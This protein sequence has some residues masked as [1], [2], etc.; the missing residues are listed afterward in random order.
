[1]GHLE[2]EL[3]SDGA[4]PW[5]IAALISQL[6]SESVKAPQTLPQSLLSRL[7]EIAVHH[8]GKVPIH[9]WLFA[10]WM[11]HAYPMECPYPHQQGLNPQT[12]AEWMSDKGA[13]A[14]A[15]AE[16]MQKT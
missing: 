1:M 8:G 7:N 13:S 3:A 11:H 14:Q 15:T 5:L 10:Q 4:E 16:E 9:G 12:A 6:P 2:A